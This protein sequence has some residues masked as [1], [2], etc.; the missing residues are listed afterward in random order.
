M[1]VS[2]S[3]SDPLEA[4]S[5][6]P[7]STSLPLKNWKRL[8]EAALDPNPFFDP[9]FLRPFLKNMPA[10]AV[11]LVV[12]RD[13]KTGQWLMAAPVGKRRLG[14]ALPANT[15]WTTDY[16]PLG[17]PLLHPSA[18]AAVITLFLAE[19][20]GSSQ[21]LVIPYMPV[22]S[23]TATQML[24]VPD[25]K[26]A[27]ASPSERANHAAGTDGKAQ[28]E[29]AYSGKRRKEMRRLLRRLG[30]HGTVAEKHVTGSS[31]QDGFETF[32]HLEAKGWKGR[33]GTALLNS[34]ETAAFSRE[35]IT[36]RS[37]TDGVRIDQ[38][39]AG[40]TLVAALVLLTDRDRVFSWK[41]AF[42]EDFARYSPGA[43]IALMAF[44]ENL[45]RPGFSQADSLAI[46][47]HSM[48]EPL[49]RGRLETAT[50][51]MAKGQKARLLQRIAAMDIAAESLIRK[52]AR[53]LKRKLQSLRSRRA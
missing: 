15:V 42:D 37:E 26:T 28:L 39:W 19:A 20:G 32:L 22:Q 10:P 52:A 46:P 40:S 4:V 51:L 53:T 17:T 47:G 25:W 43:Q 9:A 13:A 1:T 41:I 29:Q 21:L 30:D 36:A 27:A 3:S 49:W 33:K 35:M 38:L 6:D 24:A 44:R 12:V 2:S 31:V 23:K 14:L 34:P 16:A 45:A 48:I 18:D 8:S 7:L 50:L 5:L 11:R